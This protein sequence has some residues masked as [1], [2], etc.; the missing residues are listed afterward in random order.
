M[1]KKNLRLN[2]S[3]YCSVRIT[4]A[5]AITHR[6]VGGGGEEGTFLESSLPPGGGPLDHMC[7]SGVPDVLPGTAHAF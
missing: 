7:G 6:M 1:I 3:R 2:S 5:N 4:K